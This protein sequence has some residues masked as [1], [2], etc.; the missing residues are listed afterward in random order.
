MGRGP[1]SHS[2]L[3]IFHLTDAWKYLKAGKRE[4]LK[5]ALMLTFAESRARVQMEAYLPG[6]LLF[7]CTNQAN[8]L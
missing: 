2:C 5:I 4:K 8:E 1:G 6:V 7:T 3:L